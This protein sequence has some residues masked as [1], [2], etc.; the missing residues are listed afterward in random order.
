VA[1]FVLAGFGDA[2]LDGSQSFA[3]NSP[4]STLSN[5][6]KG[7]PDSAP[8]QSDSAPDLAVRD[9]LGSQRHDQTISLVGT[10]L[11]RTA[12]RWLNSRA[13]NSAF[14]L[15]SSAPRLLMHSA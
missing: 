12:G 1:P 14:P 9:A 2:D 13:Y 8:G 15:I 5:P 7:H 10:H 4:R 11:T 6:L 3:A